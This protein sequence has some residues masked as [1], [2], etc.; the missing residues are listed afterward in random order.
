MKSLSKIHPRINPDSKL[1]I[2]IRTKVNDQ[3][4]QK[5]KIHMKE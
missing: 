5:T 3:A 1:P 2:Q 4:T